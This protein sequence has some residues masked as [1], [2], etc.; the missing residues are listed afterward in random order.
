MPGSHIIMLNRTKSVTVFAIATVVSPCYVEST[1]GSWPLIS[2]LDF[3]MRKEALLDPKPIPLQSVKSYKKYFV[4]G[5]QAHF[6]QN[7]PL[8]LSKIE[9]EYQALEGDVRFAGASKNPMD[10]R[11]DFAAYFLSLIKVLDKQG[12]SFET[13]RHVS[14]DIAVAFVQPRNR[15]HALL[16]RLPVKLIGTK[17]STVLLNVLDRKLSVRGHPDGFVSKIITDKSETLGLGYGID[18]LECGICKLFEKQNYRPFASILCEVDLI[19]SN[20]AGLKLVR[21][22]TIATGA[23]KCDFRFQRDTAAP[24]ER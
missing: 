5:I 17:L 2:P 7:A 4:K 8:L 15:V 13:I 11:L 18:I 23:K 3:L 9:T 19:T 21:S 12:E 10:G 16:K 24:V 6:P 20:M 1:G 14:L 22:G